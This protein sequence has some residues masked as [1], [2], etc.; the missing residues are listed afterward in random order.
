MLDQSIEYFL[1]VW[2]FTSAIC[3][4]CKYYICKVC[5]SLAFFFCHRASLI[6]QTSQELTNGPSASISWMLGL[7]VYTAMPGS[8]DW[9]LKRFNYIPFKLT[10]LR[11][12]IGAD[13]SKD[14]V[15]AYRALQTGLVYL[16]SFNQCSSFLN[17]RIMDSPCVLFKTWNKLS[18]RQ[19]V[20][21]LPYF[22]VT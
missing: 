17:T 4:N 10:Y 19:L 14:P 15:L 8:G 2:E 1:L 11:F 22:W 7:Q 18:E 20:K 16:N 13:Y 6:V 3:L 9:C 12:L 21:A 5:I